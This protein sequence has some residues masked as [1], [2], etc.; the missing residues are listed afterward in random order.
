[1]QTALWLTADANHFLQ[2]KNFE[3]VAQ[4]KPI[5]GLIRSDIAQ[6]TD[7]QIFNGQRIWEH[8]RIS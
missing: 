2:D 7:R 5:I 6:F 3:H 4:K 1:M 8:D